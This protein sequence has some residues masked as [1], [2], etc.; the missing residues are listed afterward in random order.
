MTTP[1]QVVSSN[2]P[3]VFERITQGILAVQEVILTKDYLQGVELRLTNLKRTNTNDNI[4][5]ALDSNYRVLIREKFSSAGVRDGEFHPFKPS[6][7]LRIGRGNKIYLCIYSENG[8]NENSISLLFNPKLSAGGLYTC[9]I[10]NNDVISSVRNKIRL[11]PGSLILRI[12]ESDTSGNG[13]FKLLLY[14]LSFVGGIVIFFLKGIVAWISRFN[15]KPERSYILLAV[16]FG[17]VMVFV[18][19]PLQTPDEAVH[20]ERAYMLSEGRLSNSAQEFPSSIIKLND[21]FARL[22]FNPD[23][24]TSKKEILSALTINQEPG[25]RTKSGALEFIIPYIPQAIGIF[26]GR[27]SGAPIL[28]LLYIGRIMNLLVSVLLVYFAIRWTPFFKWIFFLVGMM[29]KTLFLFASVSKDGFTISA[30]LLLISLFLFYAFSSKE[31]LGTR[32]FLKICF[33]SLLST[34]SKIPNVVLVFLF[35]LIPVRKVGSLK[36]YL[37]VFLILM[38]VV[39]IPFF[40][41]PAIRGIAREIRFSSGTVHALPPVSKESPGIVSIEKMADTL[42]K[43]GI[44]NEK[45]QIKYILEDIPRY[46]RLEIKTI[47]SVQGK[48]ILNGFVGVL[49]WLDTYLPMW[50]TNSYLFILLLAAFLNSEPGIKIDWKNRI[51]LLLVLIAAVTIIETGMYMAA[52]V[53]GT[54]R[55]YGIQGRYFIQFAPLFL[56]L[57]YNEYSGKKLNFVFSFRKGEYNKAKM[58]EKPKIYKE[59]QDHEQIFTRTFNFCLFIFSTLSLIITIYTM[60]LR[61]YSW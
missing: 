42:S 39:F 52:T 41:G 38:L 8:E 23:E 6:E 60:E 57:F 2:K 35:S 32:D 37:V 20:L 53:V 61:Y 44:I 16:V 22:N 30:S 58:N 29:P 40:S 24:K 46:I 9:R 45:E 51:V 56:I 19:P 10:E 48:G 13:F 7:S 34:L 3:F 18:T 31:K 25:I 36:K 26:F 59:I 43:S 17:L 4:F 28:I 1:A 27:I 49:G 11:Y 21:I 15:L 14:F 33:F 50:L 47:F 54:N 5:F 12:Y 55:I